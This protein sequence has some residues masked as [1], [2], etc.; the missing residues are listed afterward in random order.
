[1]DAFEVVTAPAILRILA[2]AML[3]MILR[4]VR[5]LSLMNTYSAVAVGTTNVLA[6]LADCF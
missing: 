6:A 1:M 3:N 5:N 4:P 2:G